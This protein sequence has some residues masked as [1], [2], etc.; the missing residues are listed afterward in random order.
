VST[1]KSAVPVRPPRCVRQ[2]R[3]SQQWCA[4]FIRQ[5]HSLL[6]IPWEQGPELTPEEH[7]VVSASLPE[8]QQ[9]EGLEGGHFF[10]CVRAYGERSGDWAYVE[11]HRLFMAEEQRH[12]R[13]LG[14]FLDMAG[15]PLL[16]R[17]SRLNKL[18]RWCGSRGGLELTLAIITMVE[19][20][21][22]T[23]YAA[24]RNA[25]RS[26]VLRRICTQ[27]MR[28]EQSHVRFQCEQLARL[29]RGRTQ[30]LMALTDA[31]D[32]LLFVCAGLACWWG[33]RRLFHAAGLGFV[34]YWRLSVQKLRSAWRQKEP[35]TY[36]GDANRSAPA[37]K[38]SQYSS[39]RP[40]DLSH[41]A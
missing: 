32:V 16:R 6:P 7:V 38:S 26:T 18:F 23:Y 24:L 19:V 12:A 9:G 28:D 15:I 14:R 21:A 22:R 36:P 17:Q 31:L 41:V 1:L 10:R 8:F 4:Y 5:T 13:D 11:A 40:G 37:G 35:R 34:T 39:T 27:I 2:P 29:R 25:T 33:H 20:L 30:W 3:S